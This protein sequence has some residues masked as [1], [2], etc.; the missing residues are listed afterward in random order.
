MFDSKL[1]M[2]P[3]EVTSF[4]VTEFVGLRSKTSLNLF[5]SSSTFSSSCIKCSN[6]VFS[7]VFDDDNGA[8]ETKMTLVAQFEFDLLIM[9]YFSN[10]SISFSAAFCLSL[11]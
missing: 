5:K 8:F 6:R 3:M 10:V 9:P 4:F 7:S 11:G 2:F 1:S